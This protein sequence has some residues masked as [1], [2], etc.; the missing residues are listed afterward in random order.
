MKQAPRFSTPPSKPGLT[1]SDARSPA[2]PERNTI[3]EPLPAT[4]GV[5]ESRLKQVGRDDSTG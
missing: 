3:R 5:A 1:K 2:S 4:V